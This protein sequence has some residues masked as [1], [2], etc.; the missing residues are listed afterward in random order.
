MAFITAKNISKRYVT[1]DVTVDALRGVDLQIERGE[2]IAVTGES[3]SGKSTLLALLGGLDRPSTGGLVVDGIDVYGLQGERLADFRHEYLGFLFQSFQL[4]SY[5]TAAENV[6][7]PLVISKMKS[8]EKR[9]A[10]AH[11]LERV[12]LGTKIDRLPHQLSGGEQ[13]RVA[14]ARSIVNDPPVLLCDEPTGNLD[15]KTGESVMRLLAELN[16]EGI[17]VI[18]VT[19]NLH[20]VHYA[21]RHVRLRDGLIVPAGEDL[22]CAPDGEPAGEPELAVANVA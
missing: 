7:L 18:M 16:R 8:R 22:E 14:L 13:E 4:I 21:S 2:F 1:G 12:G 6:M 19:H 17:T 15:S 9:A 11:A 5:L 10:A 20:H 3:G